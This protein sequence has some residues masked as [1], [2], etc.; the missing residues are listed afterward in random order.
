MIIF[1]CVFIGI[2]CSWYHKDVYSSDSFLYRGR[3]LGYIQE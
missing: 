1:N 3:E 2:V